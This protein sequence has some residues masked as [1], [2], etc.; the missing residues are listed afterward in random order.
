MSALMDKLEREAKGLSPEERERLAQHLLKGLDAEPLTEVDEA[1][2]REAERRYALWKKDPARALPAHE[3]LAE[4][5]KEL[6][7]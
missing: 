6:A 7:R 1:W 3:A 4:V 2:V 5:R